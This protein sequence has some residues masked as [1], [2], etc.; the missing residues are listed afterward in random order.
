MTST[1][2]GRIGVLAFLPLLIWCS[3][4]PKPTAA[5][6]IDPDSATEKL[7]C[8]APM[9]V[10]S[11][12]TAGC[13]DAETRQH[14]M[15][16]STGDRIY[17]SLVDRVG[18]DH[19]TSSAKKRI[20]PG[21][22]LNSFVMAKVTGDLACGPDLSQLMPPP[23]NA[24]LSEQ[25]IEALRQWI[26]IGAP[27]ECAALDPEAVV[28]DAGTTGG[29]SPAA[30]GASGSG[31]QASGGAPGANAAGGPTA[32]GGDSSGDAGAPP[33]DSLECTP[34]K[35][36]GPYEVCA[37]GSCS[38]PGTCIAHQVIFPSEEAAYRRHPCAEERVAY[39][40]CD[41]VTFETR[42]ACAD[43]PFAHPGKC[44]EGYSCDKHRVRSDVPPPVCPPGESPSVVDSSYGACVPSEQCR[45]EDE[46][47]CPDGYA[48]DV[49]T[50][51]CVLLVE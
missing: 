25:E 37:S 23:P 11:C 44:G 30:A 28:P 16:L 9:L 48:C 6:K 43:R 41:G 10:R 21:D 46:F 36:C 47:G 1:L 4:R 31:G 50:T 24:P 19:C 45:C 51:T 2:F 3:E 12:A 49:P 18:L 35:P 33:L 27:R 38:M 22:P 26:A 29:A 8:V 34:S 14:G 32:G 17:D 13:H 5:L 20:A 42:L 15:D 40:G 7:A 39:C